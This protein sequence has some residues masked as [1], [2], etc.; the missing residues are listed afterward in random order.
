MIL[1]FRNLSYIC[2]GWK[3]AKNILSINYK[4]KSKRYICD[5]SRD[6]VPFVQFKKREK[7]P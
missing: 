5:A 2:I 6:L 1:F 3:Q 7:H 4:S